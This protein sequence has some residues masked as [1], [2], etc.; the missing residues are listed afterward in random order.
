MTMCTAGPLWSA[1]IARSVNARGAPADD[2][3]VHGTRAAAS[4]ARPSHAIAR[5]VSGR[6]HRDGERRTCR[7]PAIC[8]DVMVCAHRDERRARG[9]SIIGA[10]ASPL[11]GGRT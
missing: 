1:A 3:P 4:R 9:R 7:V 10:D 6:Q 2:A 8:F 5:G 11:Q